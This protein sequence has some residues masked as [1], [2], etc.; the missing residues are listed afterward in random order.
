M[1][2]TTFQT[3]ARLQGILMDTCFELKINY[4]ICPT[5]TWRAHHEVKGRSR[6]DKKKSM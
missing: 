2:V 1:G 4:K 3:L 5:N 6:A